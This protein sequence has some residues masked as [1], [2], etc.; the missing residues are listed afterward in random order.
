MTYS[1]A[2]LFQDREIAV[3]KNLVNE[4][5]GRWDC[6]AQEEYEDLLQQCLTHWFFARDKYNPRREASLTTFMAKIIRNKLTDLV[7]EANAE[8]R[9]VTQLSVPLDQPLGSAED[10]G[11]LEETLIDDSSDAFVQIELR[12]DLDK[13]TAKLSPK[14]QEL[15]RLLR[16]RDLSITELSRLL[17]TPRAT[18]YDEINRIKTLFSNEGLEDYLR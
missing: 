16:D 12:I 3:T 14:Q 13:A 2:R 10:A 11:T 18:I 17:E 5:R 7:R 4:Y 6:L 15:C 1:C 9:K 8:K